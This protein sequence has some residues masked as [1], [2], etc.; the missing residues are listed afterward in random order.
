MKVKFYGAAGEV[1]GSCHFVQVGNYRILLDCGLIQG[2]YRDDL[3]NAEPFAFDPTMIDAVVLSHS[4]LDHC[5]RIPLLVKRGFKG[6]VYTHSVCREMCRI[7]FKDAANIYRHDADTMNRKRA[8]KY[9]S[10]LEPLYTQQDADQALKHF[11]GLEYNREEE[12]LPGVRIRLNDAGHIIG[13]SIVELW[14]DDGRHQRKLVFSGDLGH[15]DMPILRAPARIA[16]ADLL[17]MEST[18]GG[19]C[20]RPWSD[21]MDEMGSI[22]S[23]AAQSKGNILIPAFAVG[24]TQELLY[25]FGKY[26]D[27]WNLGHWQIF[28]DS[29]MAI[30]AT[31]VYVKHSELY[32]QDAKNTLLNQQRLDALPNLRFTRTTDES[33]ALNRISSGAII[34]AGSGMCE[35]GRIRH[36]LKNHAWK[37]SCHILMVGFQAKGTLGRRLVEGVDSI[38][39]WHEDIRVAAK[40][41]TIGSF[42]AHADQGELIRWLGG[43]DYLPQVCLVHGEASAQK[44][45]QEAIDKQLGIKV[46]IAEP[47]QEIDLIAITPH[48]H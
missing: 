10:P 36:H 33:M 17:L 15:K 26:F 2:G 24:R 14:L 23:V 7:M 41:H 45:L 9:L 25:L 29:P 28:L 4:H 27:Q 5:G 13:A 3:R 44:A 42:S 21:S 20:H 39:I 38:K 18:Y 12:I 6:A 30:E 11:Y 35:G 37:R 31:E 22:L 34:I 16:R 48:R 46:D 43:F 1:T 47:E 40:V 8:R 32:N 19:R